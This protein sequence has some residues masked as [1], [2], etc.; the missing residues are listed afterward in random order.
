MDKDRLCDCRCLGRA[1]VHGGLPGEMTAWSVLGIVM[2]QGGHYFFGRIVPHMPPVAARL[3]AP[4]PPSPDCYLT[5]RTL[6]FLLQYF[7]PG[8]TRRTRVKSLTSFATICRICLRNSA[9][10]RAQHFITFPVAICYVPTTLNTAE[11]RPKYGKNFP[12]TI[13]FLRSR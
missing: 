3:A 6:L 2:E 5:L 7:R 10:K 13:P 8:N 12:M 1:S 11:K 4:Q 9:C